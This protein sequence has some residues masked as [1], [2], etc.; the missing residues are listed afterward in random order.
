MEPTCWTLIGAA[1]QGEDAARTEFARRYLPVVRAALCALGTARPAEG[2]LEDAVDE[3]FVECLKPQGVLERARPGE[4][5]GFRAFLFA[6]CR[7]VALRQRSRRA[8]RRE[9]EA[10]TGTFEALTPQE[11]QSLGAAFDRAWAVELL[12]EASEHLARLAESRGPAAQ[13]RVEILRLRFQEGL[14][15]REISALLGQA[16]DFVHHEYAQARREFE[17]SLRAVLV[18]HNPGDPGAAEREL[19]ELLALF[20]G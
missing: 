4:G 1:S 18:E 15:V 7:N 11:E 3:V 17:R 13:R 19:I 8:G 9:A 12:R 20:A 14:P 5:A 10:G 16:P 2:D 6:T